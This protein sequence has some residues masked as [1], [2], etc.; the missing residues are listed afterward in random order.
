MPHRKTSKQSGG[1]NSPSGWSY[2][3][4]TVGNGWTQFQNAL[5]LQPGQN[6]GSIQSN[7]IEPINNINAQNTES[8]PTQK[9]LS[10][11]QKAGKKHKKGGNWGAVLGQAA[12]PIALIGAQHLYKKTFKKRW[13]FIR[14]NCASCGPS[15]FNWCPTV[16]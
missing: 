15:C 1:N 5:T 13:K 2:V 6:L 16:V 11:I 14:I 8:F 9:E 3:Y 7:D 10:L 4:N 12:A